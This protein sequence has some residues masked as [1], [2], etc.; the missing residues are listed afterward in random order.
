MTSVIGLILLGAGAEGGLI[1]LL[2][3]TPSSNVTGLEAL[4]IP[5]IPLAV[6]KGIE[7]IVKRLTYIPDVDTIE[8][9]KKN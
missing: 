9:L 1:Y 3:T 7:M 8:S 2:A 4:G 5:A 6:V